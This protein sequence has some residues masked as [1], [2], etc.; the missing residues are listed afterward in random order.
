MTH[1]L[2]VSSAFVLGALLAFGG[3][4]LGLWLTDDRSD[5]DTD[6]G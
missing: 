3:V 1:A 2:L 5:S 6:N 4:A